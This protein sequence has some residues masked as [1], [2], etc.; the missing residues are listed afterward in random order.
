MVGEI[1]QLIHY[2]FQKVTLVPANQMLQLY[3]EVFQTVDKRSV[4][5]IQEVHVVHANVFL[6][7]EMVNP[8]LDYGTL[9]TNGKG[10]RCLPALEIWTTFGI[11]KDALEKIDKLLLEIDHAASGYSSLVLCLE[12][13][14]S[15][16]VSFAFNH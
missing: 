9:R 6:Q 4:T 16:S 10:E 2:L 5:Y 15:S 14:L 7:H 3:E 1:K 13:S 8:E 11:W 12:D